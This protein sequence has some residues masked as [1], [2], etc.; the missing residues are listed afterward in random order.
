MRGFGGVCIGMFSVRWFAALAGVRKSNI[1]RWLSLLTLLS[2]LGLW[3]LNSALYV[4]LCVGRVVI[5]DAALGFQILIVPS[6]ELERKV[7]FA[8]R[9]QWT[10][11]TSRACSVQDWMGKSERV[12]SKSLT[13]PS[14]PAVRSWFSFVS[15]HV[16]SKRESWVSKLRSAT[17][18]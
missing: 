16:V 3:G 15:D 2:M 11:K 14:P 13:E 5:E 10:E 17:S 4:Q 18:Q 9:F 6:Q 1:R 8:T 12:M 7:S